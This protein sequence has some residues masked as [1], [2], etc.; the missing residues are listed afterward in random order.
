MSLCDLGSHVTAGYMAVF[1]K[2]YNE[3]NGGRTSTLLEGH[4][5]LGCMQGLPPMN[6]SD[7]RLEQELWFKSVK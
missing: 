4:S 6:D 5:E 3:H 2:D 1:R 7:G